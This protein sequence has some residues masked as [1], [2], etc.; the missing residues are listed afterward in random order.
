MRPHVVNFMDQM[1]R[2]EQGL[3]VEELVIPADFASATLG[4]LAPRA[5][6]YLVMAVHEQGQWVFNPPD[7]HHVKAG[8]TLVFMA[9]HDGRTALEKRLAA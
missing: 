5:Q 1:L 6:E 8:S 2:S 4:S 9:N 3:R 7:S